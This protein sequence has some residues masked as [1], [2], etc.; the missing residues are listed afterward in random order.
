[1]KTIRIP[2]GLSVSFSGL[3]GSE[4]YHRAMDQVGATTAPLKAVLDI[5]T[6]AL[7]IKRVLESAPAIPLDPTEFISRLREITVNATRLLSLLPQVSVPVL[8]RDTCSVLIDLVQLIRDEVAA[9]QAIVARKTAVEAAVVLDPNLSAVVV[10]IS[11][12]E[13]QARAG[14]AEMMEPLVLVVS[15]VDTF[16]ELIGVAPLGITAEVADDLAAVDTALAVIQD[17]LRGIA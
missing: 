10:T 2:G 12:Q 6:F 5:L 3:D 15:I 4:A 1:M 7:G 8:V 16:L 14:L 13:A 11:A 17:A 9:V